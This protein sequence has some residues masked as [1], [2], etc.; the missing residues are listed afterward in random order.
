MIEAIKSL[1]ESA[2]KDLGFNLG[3]QNDLINILVENPAS[4]ESYKKI[5]KIQLRKTGEQTEY[6]GIEID[7]YDSSKIDKLLYRRGSSS[8][9]DC[10]PTS[11]ITEPR[12]TF[13]IK[14]LK[15]FQKDNVNTELTREEEIFI[16]NIQTQLINN[17][18]V[19]VIE[20]HEIY[21]SIRKEKLNAILTIEIISEENQLLPGEVECFR[22]I[23]LNDSTSNFYKK[24]NTVSKAK[25]EVCFVCDRKK[26]VLGFVS[27][28]TFYT[29]DKPGMVAGG[30]NQSNT[31]K[32]YPVC[33]DCALVLEMGKKWL[34]QNSRFNFYGFDYFL[35]PKKLFRTTDD[36][37]Y[38]ALKDYHQQ[39]SQITITG[40]YE[41]LLDTTSDEV[42]GLLSEKPNTFLCN[43]LI[44]RVSKSEFKILR[45]IEGIYPSDLQRLFKAKKQV[46]LHRH[47]INTKIPIWEN[48]KKSGERPLTFDFGCFWYF[49]IVEKQKNYFLNIINDVF[50]NKKI[51][52]SFLT[53]RIIQQIR[54]VHVNGFNIEEPVMR[55][56][57]CLLYLDYL[58]L[59]GNEE[60]DYMNEKIRKIFPTTDSRRIEVAERLF[61]EYP[62]FFRKD[63]VKAIFLVGVLSQLLMNI[64]LRKRGA[65]PFRSKLQGLKLDDKIVRALLLQIQN[66]LDEYDS[67]YYRDLETLASEYFIQSQDEWDLS[68]DEISFYFALGM[69]L[70]RYFTAEKEGEEKDE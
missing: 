4:N 45:Y 10:S 11:R 43:M 19:I 27:T 25:N 32:N 63:P 65:T 13:E 9:T 70:S 66:K 57:S 1:G 15:W 14:L 28:F 47:I 49:F 56:F 55:G 29:V 68:K 6:I 17:Q 50:T 60:D 42:L 52:R 3:N 58:G 34:E 36:A 23:F 22:K 33:L 26:E 2:L 35:I 46:E 12:K 51:N 53:N 31:W 18:D 41:A 21:D 24:H 64:Q 8:G 59:L 62:R 54:R 20:L 7:E 40:S 67:N 48:K 5:I 38:N 16:L 69:N 44:F 61:M 37:V 39:G 30:F